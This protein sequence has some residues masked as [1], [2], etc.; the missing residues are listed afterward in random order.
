MIETNF[1]CLTTAAAVTQ[2]LRGHL[3]VFTDMLMASEYKNEDLPSVYDFLKLV[4]KL[5]AAW[6][7]LFPS[8][9][10]SFI[11]YQT[12]PKLILIDRNV[13]LAACGYEILDMLSWLFCLCPRTALFFSV[14]FLR[15]SNLLS[16]EI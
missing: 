16:I 14:R 1:R 10:K 12:C 2:Y 5:I 7:E 13:A 9:L 15:Y 8:L 4:A 11:E 6:L 3:Y